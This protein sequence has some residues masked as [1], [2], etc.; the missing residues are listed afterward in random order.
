MKSIVVYGSKH[1]CAKKAAYII[2]N[3]LGDNTDV[4]NIEKIKLTNFESYNNVIIGGSIHKGKIQKSVSRFCDDNIET[5]LTKNIGLF[6][7][8]SLEE[9][10]DEQFSNSFPKELRDIAKVKEYF[11]YEIDF[12]KLGFFEKLVIKKVSGKRE[13]SFNLNKEKIERM[14]NFFDALDDEKTDK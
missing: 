14:A 6:L 7:C 10:Y 12:E 9:K 8:C 1:G 3:I 5:L 2:R 11:G 4:I 13:S